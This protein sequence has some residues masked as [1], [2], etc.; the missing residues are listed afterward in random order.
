MSEL[1]MP[2]AGFVAAYGRK[3]FID[4]WGLRCQRVM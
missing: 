4:E 2:L 1:P 3:S